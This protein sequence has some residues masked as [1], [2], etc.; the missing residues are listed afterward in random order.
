MKLLL[1][2]GDQHVGGHG[3]PDLRLHR[4]LAGA[5][6]ALDA[7][8]LLDPFE[9]Q[10]DLPA[11]LVQR[12]DGQRR[13]AVLLVRKTSVLPDSGSLKR[14]RRKCSGIVLGRVE[15]IERDGLIADHAGVAVGRG[16]V[17][18]PCIHAAL[19]AGDEEGAGLMQRVQPGEVH[20]APIHHVEGAG[21]DRQD[22]QHVDVVQLA[23][24]DVDEGGDRAAQVQQRVQLDGRL[25]RA[26]RRPVEQA[27]AQVDGGGVQRI[28]G[29]VEL[30]ARAAR[31][32]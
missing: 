5:Q 28:D 12:G 20:I 8:M 11:A 29:V 31:C 25:G 26:K 27:Q 18:A 32:A 7:Q 6:K 17:H 30:D 9:E 16:R 3:A 2:D 14:M 1:D 10:L 4:V 21:L 19:G 24:A 23:V 15:A 13:Q 22:V